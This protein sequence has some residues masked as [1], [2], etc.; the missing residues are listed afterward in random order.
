M[1]D[2]IINFGVIGC[3]LMGREFASAA[4]RW[5]HLVGM[6]VRPRIVAACDTSPKVLG[7]FCSANP[8][9]RAHADYRELLA[10]TDIEALYI[11]IPHHLHEEVYV[12]AINA[13]K[14]FL[15]EKPFGIDL[16]ANR[17]ITAALRARPGLVV[18]CSSEFPFF[19]GVQ[20]IAALIRAGDIGRVLE[21]RCGLLHSS[22]MDPLKPINWKRMVEFNG[23][24]GCMGDLG[25]H[26]VHFPLRMGFAPRDV[27]AL[28]SKI[29]GT[30]PDG[31][32]GQAPCETWDNALLA[33]TAVAPA[34]EAFPM[35]LEMKRIAPGHM[36][37][38]FIEVYGTSCSARFSTRSPRTL[39]VLR[40]ERGKPQAWQVQD[41]GYESAYPA[42]TGAIFEFGFADA[43]QQMWS[44]YCDEVANGTR[45]MRQPFFC[46]TPGEAAAS[47]ELFDAA[48]RSNAASSVE[49]VRAP[50]FM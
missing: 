43:I 38:W 3:G 25:M 6:N 28:L 48:L 18:R 7:E 24:Y 32:G 9:V 50:S 30:R 16:A 33:C 22:D 35:L 10:A 27:R 37:T 34:G 15:G 8:G 47:H 42:I 13:G 23:A 5:N 41:L 26:A 39:E 36:N 45:G 1:A 14:H 11:A 44:A 19:P 2:R 31:K 29:V 49:P 40:Y 46:A 20:K 17:A 12:A 4:A 21:V